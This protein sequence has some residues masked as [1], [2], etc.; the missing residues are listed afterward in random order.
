M[1]SWHTQEILAWTR[2]DGPATPPRGLSPL[3]LVPLAAGLVV[4]HVGLLAADVLCPEH[5]AWVDGIAGVS[6]V[7][8]VSAVVGLLRGWAS[9][10]LLAVS[11]TLGGVAIGVID[12]VHDPARGRLIALLFAG[13]ALASLALVASNVRLW[14]WQRTV[15]RAA[16]ASTVGDSP[17]ARATGAGATPTV[18]AGTDAKAAG[19]APAP[20][21][22]VPSGQ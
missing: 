3:L 16:S 22:T 21:S 11:A 1:S 10:P 17:A 18:G 6:T 2:H 13:L 12:A 5:R 4:V 8:A 9:A 7:A 15:L 14:R 19:P 20:R